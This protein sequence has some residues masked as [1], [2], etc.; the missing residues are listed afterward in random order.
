MVIQLKTKLNVADNTGAKIV[1]CIKV[2]NKTRGA[3]LGDKIIASVKQVVGH[4]KVK[5]GELVHCVI[6]RARMPCSR[7]DGSE[8]R[9]DDNA[10]VLINK[11]GEPLGTRVNGP[12]SH[13]LRQKKMVKVLSL[14]EH[15]A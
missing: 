12:V 14:A 9:F 6:V 1:E 3:R 11:Q 5:K 10:V 13:E 2:L 15:V 7:K 8:V 4:G